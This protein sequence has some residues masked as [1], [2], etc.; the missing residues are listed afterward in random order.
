MSARVLFSTELD[1]YV[2]PIAD[3]VRGFKRHLQTDS[4]M[5]HDEK[6]DLHAE[7]YGPPVA[8]TEENPAN[9][10]SS[11]CLDGK[12][13]PAIDVDVPV[14]LIPS[15]TPDHWHLY[16][17]TVEL[18]PDAYFELLDALAKAG[19]IGAGFAHHSRRRGASWLRLPG[20]KKELS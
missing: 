11:L 9:L 19:I 8:P 3:R 20:V 18:D 13:R 2:E 6:V 5:T 1:R 14:R 15:S 17:P 16:F 12:H 4:D 7:I 10:V